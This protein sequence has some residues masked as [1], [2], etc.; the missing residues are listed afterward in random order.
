MKECLQ[1][2]KTNKAKL[3]GD[4]ET[5]RTFLLLVIQDDDFDS[6]RDKIIKKPQKTYQWFIS[7]YQL[8]YSSLRMKKRLW[9]LQGDGNTVISC[10]SQT[11][12]SAG[13]SNVHDAIKSGKWFIPNFPPG[14]NKPVAIKVFKTATDWRKSAILNHSLQIYLGKNLSL[15][16]S[17]IKL[18]GRHLSISKTI[19]V[20]LLWRMR[21]RTWFHP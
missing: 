20:I 10:H 3:S 4:N 2:L 8:K 1:G 14:W 17:L 16:P 13:K 15:Q 19:L 21:I 11:T 6:I 18:P 5:L 12:S 7:R 9:R